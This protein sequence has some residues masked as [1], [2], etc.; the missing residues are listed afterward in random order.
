LPT[1][2]QKGK[3]GTTI[4]FV[5]NQIREKRGTPFAVSWSSRDGSDAFAG[6]ETLAVRARCGVAEFAANPALAARRHGIKA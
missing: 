1:L 5:C 4:G 6:R 3:N 2:S